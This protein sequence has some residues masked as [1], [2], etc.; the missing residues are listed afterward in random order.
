[1]QA[2]VLTTTPEIGLSVLLGRLLPNKKAVSPVSDT[3]ILLDWQVLTKRGNQGENLDLHLAVIESGKLCGELHWQAIS[4][5]LL[6]AIEIN[7]NVK[8]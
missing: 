1:M 2:Q 7:D 3:G 5:L 6:A 8:K 4:E